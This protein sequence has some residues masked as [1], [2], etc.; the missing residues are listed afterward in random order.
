MNSNCRLSVKLE[1]DNPLFRY[2]H[3]RAQLLNQADLQSLLPSLS[4]LEVAQAALLADAPR[5]HSYQFSRAPLPARASI[6]PAPGAGEQLP[7]GRKQQSQ[8][9]GGQPPQSQLPPQMQ[10]QR[11]ANQNPQ[12]QQHQ[13]ALRRSNSN[14]GHV[15]SPLGQISKV[16]QAVPAPTHGSHYTALQ[17]DQNLAAAS[18]RRPPAPPIPFVPDLANYSQQ[19]IQNMQAS[20]RL[21]ANN[22]QTGTPVPSQ[23]L[24]NGS[25]S[26]RAVE[27]N[28]AAA[29][30][31]M[32]TS[33]NIGPLKLPAS[34]LAAQRNF[35]N[36]LQNP[37]AISQHLKNH[38]E[39]NNSLSL[40]MSNGVMRDSTVS[41]I[42]H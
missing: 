34:R 8:G 4:H 37:A 42:G 13:Q 38:H 15:L 24:S 3:H 16:P 6:G 12:V 20:L 11:S 30:L 14:N 40:S 17:P 7:R 10:R 22:R 36:A 19:H 29:A 23:M 41:V 18:P 25:A 5:P 1:V 21:Q 31:H 33:S 26:D 39:N 28:Q 32:A 9:P 2:I 27:A 35:L